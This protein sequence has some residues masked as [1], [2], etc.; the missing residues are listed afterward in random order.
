[1]NILRVVQLAKGVCLLVLLD[2]ASVKT[3]RSYLAK[4]TLDAV[5]DLMGSPQLLK[6]HQRSMVIGM[7][8]VTA[9]TDVHRKTLEKVMEEAWEL[10]N[11]PVES[12]NPEVVEDR[13]HVKDLLRTLQLVC[14][15][16]LDHV[17][18]LELTLLFCP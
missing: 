12:V 18:H 13:E 17:L 3:S 6:M 2:E 8:K 7:T 10:R 14:T 9:K 5:I 11:V 1:M 4:L 15:V 16:D